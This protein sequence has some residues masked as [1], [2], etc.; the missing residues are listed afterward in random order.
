MRKCTLFGAFFSATLICSSSSAQDIDSSPFSGRLFPDV[1]PTLGSKA[2]AEDLTYFTSPVWVDTDGLWLG[3]FTGGVAYKGFKIPFK[4]SASYAHI[5][6]EG[7]AHLSQYGA[8]LTLSAI[9]R[10]TWGLNLLGK[11][12]NT[13]HGSRRSEV[14]ASGEFK[15]GGDESAL[16]AGV[17]VGWARR[18]NSAGSVHDII[19][20]AKAMISLP[21]KVE[22]GLEYTFDNDVDGEDDYA[23]EVGFPVRGARFGVGGGKNSTFFAYA[24]QRF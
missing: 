22:V 5:S 8:G 3:K 4:V 7:A 21:R 18:A 14:I 24:L 23:L 10:S 13:R 19:P 11:Y 9:E 2:L 12:S 20:V 16:S 15:L 17:D 6:P 1:A